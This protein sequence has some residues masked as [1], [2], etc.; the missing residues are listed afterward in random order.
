M[1]EH[2]TVYALSTCQYCKSARQL[3][4]DEGAAYDVIE[5]DLLD[6]EAREAA[7]ADVRRLSGGTSFP[8]IVFGDEVI[9]GFDKVRM[10]RLLGG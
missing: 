6:G 8:V 7:V 1:S 2:C 10:K 3:L 9:V 5:V 4:D